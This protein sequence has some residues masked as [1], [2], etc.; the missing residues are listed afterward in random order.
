MQNITIG[1]RD[2]LIL[3]VE[4]DCMYVCVLE[5]INDSPFLLYCIELLWPLMDKG[6]HF[7]VSNNCFLSCKAY[8]S[9][10]N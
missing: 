1:E 9:K 10:L 3:F 7:S 2:L 4:N 5:H 6:Y 8:S